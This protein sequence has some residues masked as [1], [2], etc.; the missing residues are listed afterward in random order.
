MSNSY[1]IK[2]QEEPEEEQKNED[3]NQ[4]NIIENIK[5]VAQKEEGEEGEEILHE[6]LFCFEKVNTNKSFIGCDTCGK[7][8]H[9]NCYFDWFKRKKSGVCISCQQ[10]TL[11][12]SKIQTTV[13]SQCLYKLFGKK[14]TFYKKFYKIL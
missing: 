4:K 3:I 13:M 11:V 8:C 10:P 14:Q 5:I 9:D 7:K 12:Y 1:F 2:L 6:C